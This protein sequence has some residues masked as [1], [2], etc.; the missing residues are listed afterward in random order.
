[1]QNPTFLKTF[2]V[3]IN[4]FFLSGARLMAENYFLVIDVGT[5]ES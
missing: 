4:N 5:V 3:I 2:I 1:M